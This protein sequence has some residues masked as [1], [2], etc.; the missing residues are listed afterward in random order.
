M[1]AYIH[2]AK[3]IDDSGNEGAVKV[4]LDSPIWQAFRLVGKNSEPILSSDYWEEA[5]I[6]CNYFANWRADASKSTG[7][8]PLQEWYAE[9]IQTQNG[10]VTDTTWVKD[11]ILQQQGNDFAILDCDT[12]VTPMAFRFQTLGNYYAAQ[13][14]VLGR[15]FFYQD[16]DNDITLFVQPS[17]TETTITEWTLW[18]IPVAIPD[19]NLAN[20]GW[21]NTFSLVSQIPYRG[22]VNLG[23]PSSMYQIQSRV[24][25]ATNPATA[26]S[27][28]TSL[29]GQ[30]GALSVQKV[31][32][33]TGMLRNV[34]MAD[35]LTTLSRTKLN[36]IS[37][38]GLNLADLQA[39]KTV[40]ST[41]FNKGIVD[42]TLNQGG[43]S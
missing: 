21:W 9:K 23:D 30:S 1:E 29:I 31:T 19:P 28:G 36:R 40:L 15:P 16:R 3:E 42:P 13:A 34:Q 22:P 12:P 26:I 32:G 37:S 18:A 27:F 7:S 5:E 39:S 8:G 38:S 24:D 43:I 10:K 14:R 2:V 17:L 20:E 33:A 41:D 11:P 35:V 4:I 25:W 6:S